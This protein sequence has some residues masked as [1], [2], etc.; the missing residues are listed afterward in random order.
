MRVKNSLAEYTPFKLSPGM[1]IKRGSPAP[2]P[3]NTA[4]LPMSNRS[5]TVSVRPMTTSVSMSTPIAL[6]PSISWRTMSLGRRNSGMPYTSTPPGVCSAS[7][8]VTL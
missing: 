8:T 5:S 1:P 2:E 3:M 6:R 4:S 7:Y